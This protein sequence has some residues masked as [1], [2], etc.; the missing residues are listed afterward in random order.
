[1]KKT[2]RRIYTFTPMVLTTSSLVLLV[3]VMVGQLSLDNKA[4]LTSL[5]RNLYFLK[6]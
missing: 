6:V 1:M 2:L 5:G 4:P 3:F